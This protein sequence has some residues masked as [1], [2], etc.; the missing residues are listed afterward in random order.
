MLS[1]G[2]TEAN[3]PFKGAATYVLPIPIKF[4]D[5]AGI[6]VM[7]PVPVMLGISKKLKG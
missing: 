6:V 5:K 4:V 1:D 3:A 7:L 2:A